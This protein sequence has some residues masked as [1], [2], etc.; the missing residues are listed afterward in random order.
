MIR[1]LSVTTLVFGYHG[2]LTTAPEQQFHPHSGHLR[3]VLA[4]H[5][6]TLP[7]AARTDFDRRLVTWQ[8]LAH[9][10]ALADLIA[11]VLTHHGIDR[12]LPA[13][14]LA[15]QMCERAGDAPVTPQAAGVLAR[16]VGQG[17]RVVVAT[18][19][20]RPQ[21]QRAKSLA[22][23][24][25]GDLDLVTSS[26]LGVAAPEP[27]FYEHVLRR[28][29]CS[30]GR[31]LWVGSDPIEDVAGP[32]IHGMHAA[33]VLPTTATDQREQ[34]TRAGAHTVLASLQELPEVLVPRA[35]P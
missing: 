34:A 2:T 8:R 19:T 10:S 18:N 3:Q 28:S 9:A 21:D 7:E 23:A 14:D 35:H 27:A 30:P 31:V 26:Q 15:V 13:E 25:R 32:R 4:E 6:V 5:D 16:L 20:C 17:Y 29:Q 11:M 22:D 24:G 33:A 12:P 1:P